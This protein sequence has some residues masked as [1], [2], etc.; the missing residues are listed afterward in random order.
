M[1][2]PHIVLI[3]AL[4]SAALAS[5]ARGETPEPRKDLYG[6]PLPQGASARFGTMRFRSGAAGPVRFFPDGKS[7]ALGGFETVGILDCAS[8]KERV[9]TLSNERVR[10]LAL[11][12]NCRVAAGCLVDRTGPRRDL[13]TIRLWEVSTGKVL[14]TLEYQDPKNYLHSMALSPDGKVVAAAG[15]KPVIRVLETMTG[16]ELWKIDGAP[17][18]AGVSH[19]SLAISPDGTVLVG[20]VGKEP[21]LCVWEVASGTKLRE[22]CQCAHVASVAFSADGTI[23]AAATRSK[24]QGEQTR[25]HVWDVGTGRELPRPPDQVG[26]AFE[27]ALAPDGKTLA[28]TYV[29]NPQQTL[30]GP[31]DIAVWEVAS[32]KKIRQLRGGWY[33]AFSPDGQ[34][35]ASTYG[36]AV[37][38][39]DLASGKELNRQFVGHQSALWSVAFSPDGK[40]LITEDRHQRQHEWESASG[41]QLGVKPGRPTRGNRWVHSRDGKLQAWMEND[42][43]VTIHLCHANGQDL[44]V[45]KT[46]PKRLG[47]SSLAFSPDGAVIAGAG[48]RQPGTVCLWEVATG[49]EVPLTTTPPGNGYTCITFS[50]DGRFLALGCHDQTVRLWEITTGK[51]HRVLGEVWAQQPEVRIGA[52][53]FSDDG[54]SLAASVGGQVRVWE[55]VTGKERCQVTAGATCLCFSPDGLRLA[56]GHGDTTALVWDVSG[57]MLLDSPRKAVQLSTNNLAQLWA[58]LA[59][60]E[61]SLAFRAIGRLSTA[62][63]QSVAYLKERLQPAAFDGQRVARLLADLESDRFAV[64]ELASH[65][66]QEQGSLAAPALRQLL[67]RKPSLEVCR[68]V[69]TLLDNMAKGFLTGEHLRCWRAVETLEAIG[70]AEAEQ[71]LQRLARGAEAAELTREARAAL[72]RLATRNQ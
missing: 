16:K 55:I 5:S 38:V 8:G 46:D 35:L 33:L 34:T 42:W 53:A 13:S 1:R 36:A 24:A 29:T 9:V 32:G 31:M 66:L 60:D 65:D 63:G 64:R 67:A 21:S 70:N 54:K 57:A 51:E 50:P 15:N 18:D 58:N 43:D 11:T 25:V 52:L 59:D 22:L 28:A 4:L 61:A 56:T 20:A 7:L 3:V 48:Y 49:Q 6:D 45:I 23:L 17:E 2:T 30:W 37:F 69:E 71:V 12:A 62:P 41:K 26:A 14:H 39:H 10:V 68:R 47:G 40:T 72:T 44:R 19:R 27:V